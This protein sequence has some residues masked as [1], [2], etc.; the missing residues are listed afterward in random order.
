MAKSQR[1]RSQPRNRDR[2]GL[3]HGRAWKT[4][5]WFVPFEGERAVI[6][7]GHSDPEDHSDCGPQVF[8]CP[9]AAALFRHRFQDGVVANANWEFTDGQHLASW[10]GPT[11]PQIFYFFFC[12]PDDW[13]LLRFTGVAA[14][15]LRNV[16]LKRAPLDTYLKNADH[17]FETD[18]R[19]K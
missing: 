13:T 3:A 7:H 12:D 15:E 18:E 17:I 10:A 11:G 9:K 2:V 4:M 5:D 1:R 19:A 14:P 16:L 6:H 8:C